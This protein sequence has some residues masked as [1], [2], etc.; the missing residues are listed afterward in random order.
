MNGGDLSILAII[1]QARH[2]QND[3]EVVAVAKAA[4]VDCGAFVRN[5]GYLLLGLPVARATKKEQSMAQGLVEWAD[6]MSEDPPP[7]KPK[8]KRK[9]KP[10]NTVWDLLNKK[11]DL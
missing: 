11:D 2:L 9:P 1:A 4:L 6:S 10:S 5:V 8:P 3:Q 7:T